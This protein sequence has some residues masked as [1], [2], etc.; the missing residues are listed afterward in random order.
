MYN[1]SS[2]PTIRNSILW[3]NTAASGAQI[4]RITPAHHV[5]SDSVVQGGYAGGTNI[6]SRRS[7]LGTLGDNGG[8]TR[9]FPLLPGSSAIE[10]GQQYLLPGHRP[11]R[12]QPPAERHLRHGRVRVARLLP[13]HHQRRQPERNGQHGLCQAAGR[14][15]GRDERRPGQ[16]RRDHLH[17]P[18]QRRQRHAIRL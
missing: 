10:L 9:T 13:D 15:R 7:L 6:L 4:W 18:R 16:R 12:G 17:R 14:Q 5:V 8:S 11:A 3:G 1:S 2:T